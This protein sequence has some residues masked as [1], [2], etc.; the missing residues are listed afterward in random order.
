MDRWIERW[1]DRIDKMRSSFNSNLIGPKATRTSLA[2]LKVYPPVYPLVCLNTLS[3]SLPFT[4]YHYPLC[5]H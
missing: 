2:N 5:Y 3:L 4:Y 1:I